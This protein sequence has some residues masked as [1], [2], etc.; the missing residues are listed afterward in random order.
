MQSLTMKALGNEEKIKK[1]FSCNLF[2]SNHDYRTSGGS[3]VNK[4]V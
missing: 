1:Q 3:S 2:F 4:Y